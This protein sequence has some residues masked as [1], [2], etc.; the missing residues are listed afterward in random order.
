MSVELIG[1]END[2]SREL[3]VAAHRGTSFDPDKRGESR[4]RE[5]R[6]TL[7]A[8]YAHFL[9]V[10][11]DDASKLATLAEEFPRYREGYRKRTTAY[12]ASSSRLVSWMIAGPSNF[13]ARRMEKRG[14]VAHKRLGE[15]IEFRQRAKA[16]ILK[17]LCPEDRPIMTGDADAA[18][19]LRAEIAEAEKRQEQMKAANAA[20]RKHSKAGPDAQIAAL[21]ALGIAEGQARR[22]LV[23]DCIGRIGFE[24]FML[25]NN[26]A[27]IRRMKGRL[28]QVE[29]L[30]TAKPVE[31]ASERFK[32]EDC[33]S[34]NRLRLFF[35]G[36]PDES[37][38][39]ALKASGF[40]WTPSLGCWQ[41]YRNGRAF[42]AARQLA[43]T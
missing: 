26:N 18:D 31:I 1:I 32:V 37:T 6:E 33:P 35:A 34:E 22:L 14:D 17:K 27:N 10:A 29:R 13:P 40:R 15:L 5:Y 7:E 20:I 43:N 42:E 23:P 12:L 8:D 28:V 2:I 41:A 30:K 25:K 38:R 11:G 16:A 3:A 21:V 24:D 39:Q 9:R 36:K 4:L 19:R